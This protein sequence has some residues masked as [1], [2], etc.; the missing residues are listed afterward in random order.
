MA[1]L[2]FDFNWRDY[3]HYDGEGEIVTA[4]EAL[5]QH[6]TWVSRKLVHRGRQTASRPS[7][8]HFTGGRI[9]SKRKT[10]LAIQRPT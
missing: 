3:Q 7:S 1:D 10:G 2:G 6:A 8:L 9:A 4:Y 5:R